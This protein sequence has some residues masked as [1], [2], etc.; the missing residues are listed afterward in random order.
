MLV[1]AALA[2]TVLAAD[3]ATT[4]DDQVRAGIRVARAHDDLQDAIDAAGGAAALRRCALG[5]WVAVNHTAQT[6]LAWEL[7][8]P[9]DR[10]A[11]TMRPPGIVVRGRRNA[12]IGAPPPI[13]PAGTYRTLGI[14]HAGVWNVAAVLPA[15]VPLPAACADVRARSGGVR[16][17]AQNHFP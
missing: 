13:A 12:A 5:G 2:M 16:P 6:A 11:R 1:A 8:I 9:L 4:L 14:A 7:R 15:G 10:A 3:R 17:R